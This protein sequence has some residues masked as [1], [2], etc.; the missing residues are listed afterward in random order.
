MSEPANSPS[1]PIHGEPRLAAAQVLARVLE[2]QTLDTALAAALP[3]V[4]SRDRGL[5]AECCYGVLRHYP[6]LCWLLEQLLR[7]PLKSRETLLRMLLLVGLYQCRDLRVPDYAAVSTTVNAARRLHKPWAVSLVNAVLRAFLRR[8]E[9]LLAR[10]AAEPGVASDHPAWM[11]ARF[12]DDWPD[13]WQPLIQAN[14]TRPPMVLRVNGRR[15]GVADYLRM[16]TEADIAARPLPGLDSALQLETPRDV[17][18]L[19][20]FADGLV[21]V[22]DGGAQLAA[23]FLAPEPGERVLDACAAPGGKTCHLLER[24]APGELVALDIDPARLA[25]LADNLVRLDLRARLLCGDLLRPEDWWDGRSFQRILVD[26]PCS[27]SG[28]IR[29]H[30]DIKL[31]R[32]EG[33]I[34]PLAE[35]QLALLAR[36]WGLLAPGGRLLYA[37][38]SVF[39]EEN[40]AVMTRFL[41]ST[42][43]RALPLPAS[44]G[45]DQAPGRQLLPAVDGTDGFY[46]ACVVK[47]H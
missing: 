18:E 9:D 31:L 22:Q 42:G 21:S 44:Q 41:A 38:C 3:G 40:T 25:R 36:A 35:R 16:L 20:G 14:N 33:D 11:L 47:P 24:F 5:L 2:G 23:G 19:P 28:V 12:R 32:R 26:A 46:Y 27:G 30:P 13:H 4:G 34:A 43:I 15:V 45:L 1:P 17:T 10:L 6:S 8:R 37:T 29:R 39:R 7:R